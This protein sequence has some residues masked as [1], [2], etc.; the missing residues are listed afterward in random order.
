PIT[1]RLGMGSMHFRKVVPG[2]TG[3]EDCDIVL[4]TRQEAGRFADEDAIA[5]EDLDENPLVMKA[6]VLARVDGAGRELVIGID[7]GSRIGWAVFYGGAGLGFHT[8]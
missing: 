5:I 4:T 7:P 3:I 6:Q 2:E 1:T 8:A